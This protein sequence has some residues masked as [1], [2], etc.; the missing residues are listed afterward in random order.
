MKSESDLETGIRR[1]E[2]S[3]SRVSFILLSLFHFL[4]LSFRERD[5]TGKKRE[6]V[7]RKSWREEESE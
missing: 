5:V 3:T 7:R 2:A 4:F 1:D 6:I